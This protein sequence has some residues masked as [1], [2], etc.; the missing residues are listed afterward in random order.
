MPRESMAEFEPLVGE[1][2]PPRTAYE[3]LMDDDYFI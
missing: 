1:P 3:R 2:P